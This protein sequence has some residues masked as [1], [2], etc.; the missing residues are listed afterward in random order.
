M[1]L[2]QLLGDG[3]HPFPNA[4]PMVDVPVI[5][6]RTTRS[7]L[8]PGLAAFLLQACAPTRAD[9]FATAAEMQ[10]ALRNIRADL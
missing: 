7:D 9:R 10:L 6:P 1:L 4:M 3:H 2:Y 5:D 8:D